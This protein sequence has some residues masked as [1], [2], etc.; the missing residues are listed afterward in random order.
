MPLATKVDRT[1]P[2]QT[3]DAEATKAEILNAA[4]EEFAKFG[5]SG[6]K[7][8]AIAAKTGVTKAMIY[9]HF[10]SKEELYKAVIQRP[11][12]DFTNAFGD[13]ELET[14]PPE[15]ALKTV[16]KVAIAHEVSHPHYGQVLLHE[17][18][19]NQGKHFKLTG[20]INPITRVIAVVERGMKEGVFRPVDPFLAVIHIMGIC[21][22]YHNA[23]ANMR[24]V[25]PD[26]E[27]FTPEA[28]ERFTE[29]AIA[30]VLAGLKA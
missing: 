1:P 18:M 9:Y 23:Q 3:R 15:E 22:F 8:E 28:I 14:M 2:R 11:A 19:Q 7:T 17:A 13:L 29:S 25:Q 10:G 30:M 6:A 4:E 26:Y 21:T 24:N 20:W 16:I 12:E 5:F 27:W